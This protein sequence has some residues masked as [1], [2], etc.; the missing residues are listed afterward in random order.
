MPSGPTLTHSEPRRGSSPGERPDTA[1]PRQ[2]D[3]AAV[4]AMPGLALGTA[5]SSPQLRRAVAAAADPLGGGPIPQEVLATLRQRRGGGQPLPPGPASQIGEQLGPVASA[6]RLHTD[7]ESDRLARSVQ[8][9]AFSYGSDV[10]FSSGS[11]APDTASGQHLLAHELSHVA[12]G[13]SSGAGGVVGRA[14][15]PAEHEADRAADRVLQALR[16]QAA[17]LTL[18]NGGAEQAGSPEPDAGVR[19]TAAPQDEVVRR[20]YSAGERPTILA[21][22]QVGGV[23]AALTI[24]ELHNWSRDD[25]VA[26]AQAVPA[27]TFAELNTIMGAFSA[28]DAITILPLCANCTELAALAAT[29]WPVAEFTRYAQ[30]NPAPTFAQLQ[31]TAAF[32]TPVQATNALLVCAGWPDLLT[33]TGL[34][35][36]AA[37]VARFAGGA[38]RPT[39]PQLQA[40]AAFFAPGQ[41][42]AVLPICA[43]GW[44]DVLMLAGLGWPAADLA[45]F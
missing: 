33:L 29:G 41:V 7:A 6:A 34:G 1:E 31:G 22:P 9:V 27:P 19:R 11:Y 18:A 16:R 4:T 35:W 40:A 37:D 43:G 36:P 2:D 3:P 30:T 45:R 5:F 32:F 15:D 17:R 10:Y 24:L 25:T 26:L 14:D 13:A 21:L 42:D 44:A 8:S 12:Q 28:A 38:V 20:V 39:V 23:V